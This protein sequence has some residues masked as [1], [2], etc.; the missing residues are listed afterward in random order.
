MVESAS[1]GATAHALQNM[2]LRDIA[3]LTK[4]GIVVFVG[5]TTALGYLVCLPPE[6]NWNWLRLILAV[7]GTSL[8]GAGASAL[9]QWQEVSLDSRMPRTTKRPIVTGA[10]SPTAA[11]SI[12]IALASFG[13]LSLASINSTCLL[14]GLSAP[15]LYNY[16][17]TI[18]W[19]P[20]RAFAAV[21]GALPGALPVLIGA[22]AAVGQ[23]SAQGLYLFFLMFLWQMPHFWVLAMRF[24]SDYA[25]GSVPTLPV[26]LGPVLTA[27]QIV[28]W[29]LAYLSVA[30]LAPLVLGVGWIYFLIFV[31]LGAGVLLTLRAYMKT[32][33]PREWIRFFLTINASLVGFLVGACLDHW[34]IYALIPLLTR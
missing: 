31:A 1:S 10:I 27:Q 22:T 12:G 29:C 28:I 9:N 32:F 34:S 8:L 14:L 24:R 5:L 11:F 23:V 30:A 17:Y 2:K 15:V 25:A 13:L 16:F 3:V 7:A 20:R 4:S 21:P 18:H 6:S 19:K 26:R 33:A